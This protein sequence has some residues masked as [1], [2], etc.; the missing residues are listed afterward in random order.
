M[1]DAHFVCWMV[2]TFTLVGMM[3]GGIVM[4]S[5]ASGD[6]A[7][8]PYLVP[9]RN[10]VEKRCTIVSFKTVIESTT[11]SSGCTRKFSICHDGSTS[12]IGIAGVQVA[13]IG[14]KQESPFAAVVQLSPMQQVPSTVEESNAINK[15]FVEFYPLAIGD[16]VECGVP[17]TGRPALLADVDIV[18]ESNLVALKFNAEK[19]E[20]TFAPIETYYIVGGILLGL[21]ACCTPILACNVYHN[22]N[23]DE[24]PSRAARAARKADFVEGTLSRNTCKY[25]AWE[26]CGYFCFRLSGG[27]FVGGDE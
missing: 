3:S 19:A 17:A 9:F 12:F 22:C 13:A 1:C 25:G 15:T 24:T 5:S 14:F 2:S 20:A 16:V 7:Q 21:A 26:W 10:Y 6:A 27:S 11:T 8:A 23:D 4:L 18:P